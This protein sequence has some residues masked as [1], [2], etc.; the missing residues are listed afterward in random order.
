MLFSLTPID[1]IIILPFIFLAG[2]LDAIA[3]GGGLISLPAYWSAGIPAHM[4][5]G[6]NKFSS[7]FGTVFSTGRYF[8]AGMIDVPVA[9]I[10]AA[11]ALLGSWL[12][13]STAMITS[14]NFL[15]YLLI[16][17]IPAITVLTLLRRKFGF[18]DS[19]NLLK[20]GYRLTLGALA[21]LVIGFYDGFFGPG[22]GTFL[23]LIY[24]GLLHY[25][26]VRANGNSKVVNMASNVAAMV[27]F[28]VHGQ[29][30]YALAIPAAVCGIAGNMVGSKMVVLR[31]N[32]LIHK[33]LV[34][35]MILLL[36]RVIYNAIL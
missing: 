33:V 17:L 13:A 5:L 30:L 9:V 32:K 26:F 24:S 11:M 2:F 23:I 10:G 16:I 34:L 27:T 8:R 28:A 31:G 3:G 36:A 15:N 21:G 22:T 18:T 6:T 4:A 29:I 12:G 1:F 14:A 20:L 19:A 25:D 35:A 7:S